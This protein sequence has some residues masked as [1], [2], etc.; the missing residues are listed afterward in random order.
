MSQQTSYRTLSFRIDR[1]LSNSAFHKL[2]TLSNEHT[3]LYNHLLDRTWNRLKSGGK[4]DFKQINEDYK[5]F[6]NENK[7]TAPS[8]SAQ[9]TSHMFMDNIK[10]YYALKK[11][12][13]KC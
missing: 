13:P 7:L 6:R 9:N 10:S 12:D 5:N 2:W 8:K 11:T 1:K 4:I 3:L